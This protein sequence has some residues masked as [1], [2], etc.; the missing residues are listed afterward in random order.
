MSILGEAQRQ[1]QQLV[2]KTS[3]LMPNWKRSSNGGPICPNQLKLA[4]SQWSAR[5]AVLTKSGWKRSRY[6]QKRY[7]PA[8]F[9]QG[10]PREIVTRYVSITLPLIHRSSSRF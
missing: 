1:T 8:G 4:S 7:F 3:P 5:P 10:L 9:A 6:S 2:Q